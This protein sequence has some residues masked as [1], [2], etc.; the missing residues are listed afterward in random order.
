MRRPLI[1]SA[2]LA[3]ALL[4]CVGL[5]S[6]A[7]ALPTGPR[8][9]CEA[10]PDAPDCSGRVVACTQC[11]TAPPAWN[12]YGTAVLL[13][14]PG[15]FDGAGNLATALAAV[16][17]DDSDGDGV[18][19][20]EEIMLGTAPGRI[21]DVYVEPLPPEGDD[22][23]VYDVGNYDGRFAFKRMK[24]V[25][26][27]KSPSYE[28][29]QAYDAA[30]DPAQHLQDAL[31]T[32]LS[33]SFW[34][35]EALHRMADKRVRPLAAVGTG[36]ESV[37][38]LADY[39]WDYRLFS[40]V[41]SDGRDVRDL[42]LA[43]YHVDESGQEVTGPIIDGDFGQPL[44]PQYRAGMI[45]TQWFLMIHTMFSELPRTTA[46][47]AYRAYLGQDIARSE[48][49]LP[50]A[51]EPIDVDNKGVAQEVC[52]RCHSTLDPL[53]Y[54]FAYY[55][56]INGGDTGTFKPGRPGWNANSVNAAF[57]DVPLSNIDAEG[58]V[59]WAHE[60]AQSDAF[61][62]T[63]TQMVMEHALTELGPYEE[64]D[65]LELYPTLVDDG[66]SAD[67]LISRFVETDAFGVP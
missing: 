65:L 45:T 67:A 33:S 54:A 64:R 24:G 16:E 44:E 11:H 29:M 50:V 35:E 10:Y 18:S 7:H 34:R 21:D 3:L 12:D 41:M 48:G 62:R 13:A 8:L 63:V 60:A 26:C 61:R 5:A 19:N 17:G 31:A 56:G 28:E 15:A 58:V 47:Q 32:C 4:G 53:A 52:A 46:A 42:L 25:F 6:A 20:L 36:A 57:M 14:L 51:G 1:P 37:I 22:N 2:P 49:L 39:A 40:H 23:P 27:G 59:G 55:D 43:D 30:A 9:F 38:P 66:H